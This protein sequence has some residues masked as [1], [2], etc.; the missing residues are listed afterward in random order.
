M[1]T[2]YLFYHLE[3]PVSLLI[4][5]ILIYLMKY[6][7]NRKG[8]LIMRKIAYERGARLTNRIIKL[9][10]YLRDEADE[11]YLAEQI[12]KYGSEIRF[13]MFRLNYAD[14]RMEYIKNLHD[15]M[16]NVVKTKQWLDIIEERGLIEYRTYISMARECLDLVDIL[17]R[18]TAK[19]ASDLGIYD[20]PDQ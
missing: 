14:D 17:M 16:R 10:D 2:F 13:C 20:F 8:W 15:A 19:L 6:R 9:Q 7:I 18:K 11:D 4:P 12:N 5:F 3:D 1:Y